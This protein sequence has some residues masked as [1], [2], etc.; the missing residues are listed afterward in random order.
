MNLWENIKGEDGRDSLNTV[1]SKVVKT[2]CGDKQHTFEI[3][4][5]EATCTKCGMG[6]KFIPGLH[7]LV[8]G[9]IERAN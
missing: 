9:R 7:K 5:R 1:I 8:D 4:G 6:S 2:Y 3:S